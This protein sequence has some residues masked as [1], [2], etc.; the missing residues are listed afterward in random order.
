MFKCKKFRIFS[1]WIAA[2][3]VKRYRM[4]HT[5]GLYHGF[6]YFVEIISLV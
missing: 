6:H 3:H 1:K 4:F 2:E 5:I